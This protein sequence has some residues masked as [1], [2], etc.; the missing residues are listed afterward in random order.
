MVRGST[1]YDYVIVGAGSAGGVL[2]N[3]LSADADIR[4]LL[5]EAG[6]ADTSWTIRMPAAMPINFHRPKY[7]WRYWTAP[8][9]HLDN[10]RIYAPRGKTLGGSS[11]INGMVY[12]RGH[13]LDY[14][15]WVE[16]GADG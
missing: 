8:Q 10:R 16:E 13:G 4:V 5:V 6:P 9:A 2:A 15:R 14:D 7:N 3:R 12:I 1:T 11:A